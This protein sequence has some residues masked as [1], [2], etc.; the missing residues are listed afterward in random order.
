MGRGKTG[1]TF[2]QNME[3]LG[4][5]MLVDKH[6]AFLSRKAKIT[7]ISRGCTATTRPN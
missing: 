3:Q 4:R 2:H 5:P 1:M 7:L 6:E